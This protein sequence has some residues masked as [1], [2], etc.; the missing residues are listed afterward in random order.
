VLHGT[1][2]SFDARNGPKEEEAGNTLRL[3]L[4]VLL[5]RCQVTKGAHVWSWHKTCNLNG[6]RRRWWLSFRMSRN[7][8]SNSTF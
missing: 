6:L 4:G 5:M 7:C 1:P 2:N 3:T 8:Y